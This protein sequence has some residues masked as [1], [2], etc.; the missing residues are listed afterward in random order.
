ML[1][2]TQPE[3]ERMLKHYDSLVAIVS[4]RISPHI[5]WL[6][7]LAADWL[8]RLAAKQAR[9]LVNGWTQTRVRQVDLCEQF[10]QGGEIDSACFL[11]S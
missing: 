4:I 7:A 3:N 1:V 2:G 6:V 10:E 5:V 11:L 9:E 8:V